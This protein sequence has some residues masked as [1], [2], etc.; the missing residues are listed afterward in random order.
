MDQCRVILL[1]AT[2]LCL[3]CLVQC[4]VVKR[5]HLLKKRFVDDYT[6]MNDY[7]NANTPLGFY[8]NGGGVVGPPGPPGPPG[9]GGSGSGAGSPGPPGPPGPPGKPGSSSN[10][11]SPRSTIACEGEKQWIECPPYRLIKVDA[12]FWGRDDTN[13]CSDP[14]VAQRR[15]TTQMCPQDE[16]NTMI[17]TEGQCNNEQ[18]CEVSATST[19]FDKTDCQNVHK[20]LRIKYRCLPYESRIKAPNPSLTLK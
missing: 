14:S 4:S 6:S 15:S 16:S 2:V 11:A 13:T 9:G 7:W 1:V 12:A 20:Y 10:D 5:P 18:A 8:V 3:A 19:F 17:K